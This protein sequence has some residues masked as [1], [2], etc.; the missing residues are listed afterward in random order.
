MALGS[1]EGIRV[2]DLYAGSGA[3]AIEALSRGA[4]RADLVESDRSARATIARNVDELGLVEKVKVWPYRLPGAL[5]RLADV[6]AECA[7]VFAD[8]PYGGEEARATLAGLGRGGVLRPGTR[9]V[10]ETHGK[11]EV[12]EV[13]GCLRRERE[14]RYGETVVHVYRAEGAPAEET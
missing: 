3:L 13:A 1:L 6:L 14:R 2:A 7:V 8:P 10:L 9:V 5:V 12:P 11:D 4:V